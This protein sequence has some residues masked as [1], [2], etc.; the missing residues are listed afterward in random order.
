MS[1]LPPLREHN[2]PLDTLE[3]AGL[4][5]ALMF[6][7]ISACGNDDDEVTTVEGR[8]LG[9]E[10]TSTAFAEGSDIPARFTC[11]DADVSPPLQWTGVPQETKSLALIVDDPDARGTWVHWVMYAIPNT[12]G[13]LP[14]A[15]PDDDV[16]AQGAR[17][18][19]N[20]FGR[21]GYGGP[22]P[23]RGAPHRYFFKVY[24]LDAMLDLEAGAKKEDL[25]RAM[26]GKVLAEGRLMGRYERR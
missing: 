7:A 19:K 25:L 6:L 8:H 20:D 12:T 10:V 5:L 4:A 21:V 23:P 1:P 14:E 15:V 18:G 26:E 16:T 13:E 22:C 2:R 11:D 17:Q 3:K 24:A 9:I